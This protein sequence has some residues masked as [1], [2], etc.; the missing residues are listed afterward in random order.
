MAPAG[1]RKK[2]A[3]GRRRA[4]PVGVW[5]RLRHDGCRRDGGTRRLHGRNRRLTGDAHVQAVVLAIFPED[6]DFGQ[7]VA[8]QEFGERLDEGDVR[9][10]CMLAHRN[11]GWVRDAGYG[12]VC[13]PAAYTQ[14]APG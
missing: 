13:D 9:L 10:M 11:L 1:R 7:V 4:A 3:K 6:L 5:R 2:K 12:P 14:A 8:A